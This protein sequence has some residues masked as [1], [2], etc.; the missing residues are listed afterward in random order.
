MPYIN[1]DVD[2]D[3]DGF[4]TNDLIEELEERMKRECS[5][6]KGFGDRQRARLIKMLKELKYGEISQPV[7]KG[8]PSFLDQMKVEVLIEAKEKYS[9]DQLKTLLQL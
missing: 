2:I 3:L 6:C 5:G 7:N 1:I 4:D 9:L 8:A